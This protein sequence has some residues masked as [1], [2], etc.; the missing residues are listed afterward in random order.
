MPLVSGGN[1]SCTMTGSAD[2]VAGLGA[3]GN[4]AATLTGDSDFTAN[5]NVAANMVCTMI[6][7]G[8][9]VANL[10]AIGN[11]TATLDAGE[12]PSAFDIAQEIWN[13][14]KTS[15][16]SAGTM[17]NALNNASS[18]GV[19]YNALAAAVWQY[20]IESGRSAEECMRIYGAVL[21]GKVSGAGTGT[22][23]FTGLDGTTVRVTTT[24]DNDG[25]RTAVVVNG[26]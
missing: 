16:N 1:I 21:A 12:R 25:N 14:Q 8:D 18:G 5:A 19:D 11:M 23:L 3:I 6:G 4:M 10:S 2:L 17:G 13:S 20:V 7:E 15:Y 24:V 9:M 22:E 26:T